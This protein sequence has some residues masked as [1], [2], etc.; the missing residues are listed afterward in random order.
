ML[1][2]KP[3]K[4]LLSFMSHTLVNFHPYVFLSATPGPLMFMEGL[5]Q[6]TSENT[7]PLCRKL[8]FQFFCRKLHKEE[9]E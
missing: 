9:L 3:T 7:N 1:L 4:L 5:F 6:I 2:R 8:L